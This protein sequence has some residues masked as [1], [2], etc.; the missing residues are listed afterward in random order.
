V[1][2]LLHLFFQKRLLATVTD[3]P[4]VIKFYITMWKCHSER[5][6]LKLKNNAEN[7]KDFSEMTVPFTFAKFDKSIATSNQQPDSVYRP[8]RNVNRHSRPGIG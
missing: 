8:T 7:K 2:Q 6:L 1:E 3:Y 4:T 5:I